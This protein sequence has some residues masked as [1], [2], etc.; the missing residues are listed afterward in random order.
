MKNQSSTH[1][2]SQEIENSI[3]CSVCV[4]TH[5]RPELLEKLLNSLN[6]QILPDNVNMEIIVVDNDFRQSAKPVVLKFKTTKR[7][8][9]YY[10]NQPEKNVSLTRNLTV[11][12]SSGEY[13]LFIDDDECAS[14]EWLFLMLKTLR[15]YDADG[16][17]GF[18]LPQFDKET[19]H[20]LQRREFYYL[21]MAD[22]G[23]P[24]R[25]AYTNNCLLKA[26]H[27]KKLK[28][29]FDPQYGITGGGD[30]LLFRKLIFQG[31]RFVNCREA[32]VWEYLPRAR[33][34][35]SYIFVN[36]LKGGNVYARVIIDTAPNKTLAI[37]LRELFKALCLIILS[38]ASIVVFFPLRVRRILWMVKLGANLGRLLAVFDWHYEKYR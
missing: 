2:F 33:A 11:E 24:A 31:L 16:V 5:R 8:R 32:V 4:A 38:S 25:Y 13:I 14:R 19:P 27:L 34:R 23:K 6:N 37:C 28:E 18:V 26:T 20:W 9:F 36:A 12:K 10:F 22:T 15:V 29:P 21:P 7:I 3:L 1:A 17:Y 35:L 30:S